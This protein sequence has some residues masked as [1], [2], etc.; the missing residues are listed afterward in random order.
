MSKEARKTGPSTLANLQNLV[1][2]DP[3]SYS[4]EF[5]QQY[6]HF[7]SVMQI[8]MLKPT[9]QGE[10][11]GELVSF[12]SAVTHCF[13]DVLKDFPKQVMD[14]LAQH[15]A[16]LDSELRQT[17]CRALILLRNKGLLNSSS[18]LSLFFKLFSVHDKQLRE[19]LYKHIVSDIKRLN[20][21]HKDNA[22]NKSLQNFMYTMLS[23]SDVIAAKK[24]LDIMIE[25]YY[26]GIWN[27]AKTVNVI[28]TACVSPS[29]KILTTAL[30]FFLTTEIPQE[31]DEED[32]KASAHSSYKSAMLS[33]EHNKKTSR[34]QH[35]LERALKAYKKEERKKNSSEVFNSAALHL[36]NDPQGLAEKMFAHLRASK[37]ERFEVRLMQMNLISRLVGVHKLILLNFY[38]F[39]QRYLQP[40]QR[41]VTHILTYVAQASHDLVPEDALESVMMTIANNFVSDRSTAESIGLGLNSI[42][43]L[44][45]RCPLAMT[46]TLLEDL[47]QYKSHRDKGVHMAARSLVSLFRELNPAILPRKERGKPGEQHD[48]EAEELEY[49]KSKALK[50][51]PGS[52]LLSMYEEQQ[53]KMDLEEDEDGSGSDKGE[54]W[55][56]ASEASEESDSGWI[57]IDH[58]DDDK[59]GKE[60][61]GEVIKDEADKEERLRRAQQLSMTR[62]LTQEDFDKIHQLELQKRLAPA[63]GVKRNH[64]ENDDI[65]DPTAILPERK[66]NKQN[67]EERLQSVHAGREDR[68]KYGQRKGKMSEHAS[69]TNKDKARKKNPMM[70]KFARKF[71]E[72]ATMSMRDRQMRKQK[73]MAK[74]RRNR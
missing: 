30:K 72:K 39:L 28:A 19:M 45:A 54:D 43:E 17:L 68:E 70:L 71:R 14:L 46:P 1:K 57:P 4:E 27:D 69:S 20:A 60:P 33:I 48:D 64:E 24:S 36:L 34:R 9:D 22:V 61:E 65:L 42:R 16:V 44:C 63:V 7:Q 31:D 12:L 41:D 55:E 37:T 35:K 40:H 50:V 74:D 2:R 21:T 52:E 18:L 53:D 26:K 73:S 23:D 3:E 25:L 62:V 51:V 10:E 38:P 29:S 56:T 67:K 5:M 11:L 59:D 15:S 47:I 8:F 66:K 6:R 58:G 32:S 13:P 49:G